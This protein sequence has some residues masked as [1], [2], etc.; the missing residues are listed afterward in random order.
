MGSAWSRRRETKRSRCELTTGHEVAALRGHTNGV[1][2]CAVTPDGRRVVSTS[3]DKTLR[4]WD[5]ESGTCLLTHCTHVEYR[6][7][8]VTAAMIVAG[9]AAGSVWFLDWPA[10]SLP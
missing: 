10:A 9:D 8:A 6:A 5:L 3:R 2:A 1:I 7:I 4:V